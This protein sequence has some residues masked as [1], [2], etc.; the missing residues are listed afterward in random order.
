M[1]DNAH[2]VVT[3]DPFGRTLRT[4]RIARGLRQIEV[5]RAAGI[6]I[7]Y[8]NNLEA[9]RSHPKDD[10][11]LERLA[12]ALG[13]QPGVVCYAAGVI[14]PSLRGRTMNPVTIMA[15][16]MAMDVELTTREQRHD[17]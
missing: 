11:I 13:V 5:A 14:P 16:W 6:S 7:Q 3:D 2:H 15:G 8:I 12:H 4:L 9:G 17:G 10:D 1:E